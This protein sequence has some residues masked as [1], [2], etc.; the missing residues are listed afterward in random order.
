MRVG[1]LILF[2]SILGSNGSAYG[3]TS[4][5]GDL[6]ED[7]TWDADGGPYRI[8]RDVALLNGSTLTIAQ[9]AVVEFGFSGTIVVGNG[10]R[11][12]ADSVTFRP[13][14]TRGLDAAILQFEGSAAGHVEIRRSSLDHLYVYNSGR[15]D[16]IVEETRFTGEG[17]LRL[18]GD[19]PVRVTRCTFQSAAPIHTRIDLPRSDITQNIFAADAVVLHDHSER[20]VRDDTI[21]TY[22]NLPVSFNNTVSVSGGARLTVLPGTEIRLGY[23]DSFLV[24]GGATLDVSGAR[25]RPADFS[26]RFPAVIVSQG[27]G[28]G[29]ANIVD[30]ILQDVYLQFSGGTGRVERSDFMVSPGHPALL[31]TGATIIAATGNYWSGEEGPRHPTNPSGDG[32]VVD[33]LVEFAPWS[34]L[35]HSSRSTSV[36]TEVF[37][38]ALDAPYPNPASSTISFAYDVLAPS[39]PTSFVYDASTPSFR[40]ELFDALGRRVQEIPVGS[41]LPPSGTVTIDVS[42]LPSG[43]YLL[44]VRADRQVRTFKIVVVR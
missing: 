18:Y 28:A 9:G 42:S 31:N 23:F 19:S 43:A 1:I 37:A 3:Q 29:H 16:F 22:G 12:I 8:T 27:D 25:I 6:L 38:A 17:H 36:E 30:T 34:S 10:A 20:I 40:W 7:V 4:V 21:R 11:L 33:G 44:R 13:V 14:H 35:P 24:N 2:C 15:G 32:A 39:A 41:S 5:T 26:G